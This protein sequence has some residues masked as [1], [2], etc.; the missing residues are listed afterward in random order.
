MELKD[1][2]NNDYISIKTLDVYDKIYLITEKQLSQMNMRKV[3]ELYNDI[4]EIYNIKY[5]YND[6]FITNEGYRLTI[7]D[8]ITA[9]NVKT[10]KGVDVSVLSTPKYKKL[11]EVVLEGYK[12]YLKLINR[13][14]TDYDVYL[15]D[16]HHNMKDTVIF[17][18]LRCMWETLG[19]C[20]VITKQN[21]VFSYCKMLGFML[22]PD[23][24]KRFMCSF[25]SPIS[26]IGKTFGTKVLLNHTNGLVYRKTEFQEVNRF[27]FGDLRGNDF[28]IIDDLPIE[29]QNDLCGVLNNI[30]SNHMVNCEKKGVDCVVVDDVRCRP[31][32]TLNYPF[33]PSND[34][35]NLVECKLIE[36]ETNKR[37]DLSNEEIEIVS[38]TIQ[39]IN[40]LPQSD[41]NDFYVL[42]CNMYLEDANFI[43]SHLVSNKPDDYLSL[44]FDQ[45]IDSNKLNEVVLGQTRLS[46]I[47]ISQDKLKDPYNK[48]IHDELRKIY[49]YICKVISK[50]KDFNKLVKTLKS[51]S[52]F[53]SHKTY[54]LSYSKNF[55]INEELLK[56][57]KS[58]KPQTPII[59]SDD[60]LPF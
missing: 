14:K 20:D 22:I 2:L 30:V 16:V 54:S 45:L 29:R 13:N 49:F 5:V 41:F 7:K 18:K 23:A 1:K 53:F 59:I 15:F 17:D 58:F 4:T 8:I 35:S 57:I 25:Y 21:V 24:S 44:C 33:R 31:L 50:T 40:Q 46:D 38:R 6:Y 60:E 3:K 36:L 47:V 26:G 56:F 9:T 34:C 28:M 55:V 52:L 43:Q 37:C 11:L 48:Q 12:D 42:C 39:T 19:V 27:T 10:L 32:L 51:D